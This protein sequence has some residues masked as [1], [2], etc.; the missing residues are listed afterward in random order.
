MDLKAK[1]IALASA[2]GAGAITLTMLLN[3]GIDPN[4]ISD[5]SIIDSSNVRVLTA[6]GEMINAGRAVD[7]AANYPDYADKVAVKLIEYKEKEEAKKLENSGSQ[8]VSPVQ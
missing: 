2:V 7:V 1:L 5:V 8:E 3:E 6:D 4:S